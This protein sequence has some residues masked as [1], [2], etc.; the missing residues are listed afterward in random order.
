MRFLKPFATRQMLCWLAIGLG[1]CAAL[2]PPPTTPRAP[3]PS[4]T[5]PA[6]P[7]STSAP[8]PPAAEPAA[9]PGPLAAPYSAAVAARFPD[10][11]VRYNTPALKDGRAQIQ[12]VSQ[13][14]LR[15]KPGR[16]G[17]RFQNTDHSILQWMDKRAGRA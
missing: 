9:T 16:H 3:A 14:T 13:V 2:A 5:A 1:G 8:T 12:P 6:A 15:L 17:N 11:A 10:P 4:A 7:G